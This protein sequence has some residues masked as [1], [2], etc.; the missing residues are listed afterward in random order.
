MVGAINTLTRTMKGDRKRSSW[1]KFELS[2][3][4][5]DDEGFEKKPSH[6]IYTDRQPHL[7]MRPV[8]LRTHT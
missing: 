4:V 8:F 2:I 7:G 1:L 6:E 3:S 5:W